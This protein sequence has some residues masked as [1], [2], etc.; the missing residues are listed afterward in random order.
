MEE[1][2]ENACAAV[3]QRYGAQ[4]S[5]FRGET[6]LFLPAEHNIEALTDLKK[7]F[8]FEMLLDLT[9]VDYWPEQQPRFH[10]LYR[11]YSFGLNTRILLRVPLDGN[12]PAI[13]TAEVVYKNA[14][15]YEREVMDLFGITFEG[16]SDPRRIMMPE[17]WQGHPLR[18]DYPLGYEEVQYTFNA[19][20]I[21][22]RKNVP[23]L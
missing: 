10:L 12:S 15:W 22:V 18:K 20:E 6:T 19:D 9:A 21:R 7:E 14:N 3:Q 1:L 17:S 5:D 23:S 13:R 8:Q 4:R 16:H 11:L 2:F